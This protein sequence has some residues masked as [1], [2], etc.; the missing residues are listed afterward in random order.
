VPRKP[1][2]ESCPGDRWLEFP[3]EATW[4]VTQAGTRKSEH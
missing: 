2:M 3:L 1:A 4:A